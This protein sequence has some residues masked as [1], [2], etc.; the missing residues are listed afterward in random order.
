MKQI[1]GQS[2]VQELQRRYSV[3][4]DERIA[5]N[6]NKVNFANFAEK[7]AKRQKVTPASRNGHV[8]LTK[9]PKLVVG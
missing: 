8:C 4:V 5:S 6:K 1:L 9:W 3:T 7:K 2:L